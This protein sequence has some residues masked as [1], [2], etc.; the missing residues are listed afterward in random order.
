MAFSFQ[1]VMCHMSA[2]FGNQAWS[3][4]ATELEYPTCVDKMKWF[5]NFLLDGQVIGSLKKYMSD[6]LAPPSTMVKT[7]AK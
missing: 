5:A 7:W 1:Q 6:L 2:T 3:I 4:P